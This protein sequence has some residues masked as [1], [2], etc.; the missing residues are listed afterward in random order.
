MAFPAGLYQRSRRE[1]ARIDNRRSRRARRVQLARSMAAL[2]FHSRKQTGKIGSAFD[3]GSV[4]TEAAIN[5][6]RA[7]LLA[8]CG[9]ADRRLGGVADRQAGAALPRVPGHAMLEIPASGS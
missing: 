5:G 2:A 6:F 3:A 8:E 1:P 7:L 9:G 4:A